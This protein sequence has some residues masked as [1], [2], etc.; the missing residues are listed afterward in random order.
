[1]VVSPVRGT[2]K[3]R[4]SPNA[5]GRALFRAPRGSFSTLDTRVT[6]AA[7]RLPPPPGRP[8]RTPLQ[9]HA[10]QITCALPA[11]RPL[12]PEPVQRLVVEEARLDRDAPVV[13]RVV[14]RSIH[15][16]CGRAVG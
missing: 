6:A 3:K 11:R 10:R 7:A 4:A 16:R 14:A 13:R 15:A 8:P 5:A 9:G 1:M 2:I 12:F